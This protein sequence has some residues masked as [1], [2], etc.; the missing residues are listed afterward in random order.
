[1]A[2]CGKRKKRIR[3]INHGLSCLWLTKRSQVSKY[4]HPF[5]KRSSIAWTFVHVRRFSSMWMRHRR[6]KRSGAR[7]MNK[8]ENKL[9]QPRLKMEQMQKDK[10]NQ[11]IE[12]RNKNREPTAQDRQFYLTSSPLHGILR[13]QPKWLRDSFAIPYICFELKASWPPHGPGEIEKECNGKCNG[14]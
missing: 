13:E 2:K 10:K 7:C 12:S 11:Y 14:I 8:N 5:M 6:G 3:K 9:E 1:M 4:V